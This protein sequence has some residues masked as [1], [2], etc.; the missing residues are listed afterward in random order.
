MWKASLKILILRNYISTVRLYWAHPTP[1]L[2]QKRWTFTNGTVY[3]C[4][5]LSEV[6]VTA[7][8]GFRDSFIAS[9]TESKEESSEC[10]GPRHGS[11]HPCLAGEEQWEGAVNPLDRTSPRRGS[12]H[13]QPS[14]SE[15]AWSGWP[16]CPGPSSVVSRAERSSSTWKFVF[17]WPS[18]FHGMSFFGHHIRMQLKTD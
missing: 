8:S 9:V 16:A 3:V 5:R 18:G 13:S 4:S 10:R 17:H 14:S 6:E 1:F 7:V 2:L 11:A 15:S 12:P